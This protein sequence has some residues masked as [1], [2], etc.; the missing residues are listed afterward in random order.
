[1]KCEHCGNPLKG[2][3]NFCNSCGNKVE[4]KEELEKENVP[5]IEETVEEETKTQ[6]TE[7]P[8]ENNIIGNVADENT[9]KEDVVIPAISPEIEKEIEQAHVEEEKKAKEK[10]EK[11]QLEQEA[12]L[13]PKEPQTTTEEKVL[14]T[15]VNE[16]KEEKKEEQATVESKEE[17][18]QEVVKVEPIITPTIPQPALTEMSTP[19]KKSNVCLIITL[20][21]L[22]IAIGVAGAFGGYFLATSN[23]E[24]NKEEKENK[25][26][27]NNVTPTPTINLTTSVEFADETLI[28]PDGYRYKFDSNGRLL[29]YNNEWQALLTELNVTYSKLV[30]QREYLKEAFNNKGWDVLEYDEK[31]ISQNKYLIYDI[32]NNGYRELA[33]YTAYDGTEAIAIDLTSLNQKSVDESWLEELDEIFSN[34]KS[35]DKTGPVLDEEFEGVDIQGE[36]DSI[37]EIQEEIE[38]EHETESEE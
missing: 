19:Q 22:F 36:I 5:V 11:E 30:S 37:R 2:T 17:K 1:M 28:L 24:P 10:E 7:R 29:I 4:K 26:D 38:V 13:E 32:A 23:S 14:D 8:E 35:I 6:I 20:V 12:L 9:E 25:D 16:V 21:I 18:V 3:E 27:N 15:A 34:K 33:A 31:R